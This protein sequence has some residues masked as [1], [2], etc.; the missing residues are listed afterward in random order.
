MGRNYK[1][2]QSKMDPASRAGNQQRVREELQRL[3]LEE[4]RQA[5]QLT[6]ADLAEML[7]VPQSSISRIERRTDMYLSTLRNYIHSMGG[8]LQ[9][10]A[11]FPDTGAVVIDRLGDYEDRQYTI[12]AHAE[13][14][15]T[16]RLIAEPFH[17]SGDPLSTKPL[18]ASGFVKAMK[19]LRV[20]QVRISRAIEELSRSRRDQQI[21]TKPGGFVFS[22][23]ELVA[24]GF[25]PAQE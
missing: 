18:K 4:L 3:A 22:A 6:Q 5:R 11:I 21:E 24:A 10:Q 16:Y 14:D 19:A 2:L 17:H 7:E 12:R 20:S 15:E 23:Q 1:E 9:I 25:E 8:T 13:N